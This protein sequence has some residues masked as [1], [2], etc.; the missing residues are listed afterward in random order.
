[1][2]AI[3]FWLPE[4]ASY[5]LCLCSLSEVMALSNPGTAQ[6][7]GGWAGCCFVKWVAQ[8]EQLSKTAQATAPGIVL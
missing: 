7:S 4:D 5:H 8:H 2:F 6:C 1:M 3:A